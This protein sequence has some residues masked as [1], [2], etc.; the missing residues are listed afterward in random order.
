VPHE[1]I[2]DAAGRHSPAH[3]DA[4]PVRQPR[5]WPGAWWA[6]WYDLP[7]ERWPLPLPAVTYVQDRAERDRRRW[8]EQVR[9]DVRLRR[10]TD[11]GLPETS[12]RFLAELPDGQLVGEL[13]AHE[14][15]VDLLLGY[16]LDDRRELV[17][18]GVLVA[19]EHRLLGVGRRLVEA[20]RAE[21][22]RVGVTT[23]HAVAEFGGIGFL[24]ACG[25]EVEWSR[26]AALRWER[27]VSGGREPPR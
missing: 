10:F 4:R 19:A 7:P 13:R 1:T 12:W 9:R 6:R 11:I 14:R 26:P 5:D 3:L 23:V 8:G 15:S 25:F 17:L 20:L 22:D 18:D 27:P 2:R 16:E 21:M 24:V